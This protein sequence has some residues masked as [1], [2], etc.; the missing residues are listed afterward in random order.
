LYL[1]VAASWFIPVINVIAAPAITILLFILLCDDEIYFHIDLP[2]SL[3]F[4][5]EEY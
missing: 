2:D 5:T 4:L 1:C 3:K